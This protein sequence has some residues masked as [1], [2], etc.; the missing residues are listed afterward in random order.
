MRFMTVVAV[1]VGV[2]V[3]LQNHRLTYI[4]V[5]GSGQYSFLELLVLSNV[6]QMQHSPQKL[7]HSHLVAVPAL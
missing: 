2:L 6:K 5:A 1:V 7:L 3:N 4:V